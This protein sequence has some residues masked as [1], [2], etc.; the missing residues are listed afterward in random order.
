VTL[1]LLLAV[2]IQFAIFAFLKLLAYN[3]KNLNETEDFNKEICLRCIICEKGKKYLSISAIDNII[4]SHDLTKD[5]KKKLFFCKKKNHSKRY[6]FYCLE[7]KVILCSTCLDEH[8][9]LPQNFHHSVTDDS[10]FLASTKMCR[11][12]R[13]CILELHCQTCNY[14]ICFKCRRTK[15]SEHITLSADEFYKGMG[16]SI[17]SN[18]IKNQSETR[19][20]STTEDKPDS[21]YNEI[22]SKTEI[23]F[24][25]IDSLIDNLNMIKTKIKEKLSKVDTQF[26]ILQNIVEKVSLNMKDEVKCLQEDDYVKLNL[27]NKIPSKYLNLNESLDSMKTIK[28]EFYDFE[29]ISKKIEDLLYST[30]KHTNTCNPSKVEVKCLEIIKS[31]KDSVNCLL[32]LPD[33]NIASCSKDTSIKIWQCNPTTNKYECVDTLYGHKKC[34]YSIIN[35]PNGIASASGDESIK[36]WKK[37]SEGKYT[38]YATLEGHDNFI[39]SLLYLPDE[40]L[41]SGS[42]KNIKIWQKDENKNY[43]C[44]ANLTGDP[45]SVTSLLHLPDGKIASGSFEKISIWDDFSKDSTFPCKTLLGHRGYVSSLCLVSKSK[46]A[47]ASSDCFIRIWDI[48]NDNF[49]CVE[50]FKAHFRSIN[51]IIWNPKGNLISASEDQTIKFWEKDSQGNIESQFILKGHENQVNSLLL[52]PDGNLASASTDST[53]RIWKLT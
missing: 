9:T 20:R 48:T 27:L 10:K 15:H 21:T 12:H 46:M 39:E 52:L 37:S 30:N 3:F 43:K 8:Q 44:K 14:P 28:K 18:I 41:I 49:I 29:K 17:K 13:E 25:N 34:I 5:N 2:I 19:P 45:G 38:C 16:E 23:I 22:K 31:H 33:K 51:C 42:F 47:S 26:N 40:T 6:E 50:Y 24:K 1:I 11:F 4:N 7:C 32:L 36:L 53:I 35:I